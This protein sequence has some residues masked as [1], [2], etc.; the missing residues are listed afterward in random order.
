MEI[1]EEKEKEDEYN[2]NNNN[3]NNTLHVAQIVKTEQLQHY[4]P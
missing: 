4:M 1:S 2:T 3:N